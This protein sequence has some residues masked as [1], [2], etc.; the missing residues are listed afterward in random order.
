ME[1]GGHT[2]D[3]GSEAENMLLSEQRAEA[4]KGA[5]QKA[6][7]E[8]DQLVA[9]GYGQ[10]KPAVLGS[11]EEARQQNRRTTLTVLPQR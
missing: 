1:V 5:L 3:V 7:V 9:K 11:S 4:V 10:S 6:G 2:D 8:A